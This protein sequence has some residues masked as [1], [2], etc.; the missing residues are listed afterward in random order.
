MSRATYPG[1]PLSHLFISLILVQTDTMLF[2]YISINSTVLVLE[3]SDKDLRYLFPLK[4]I[5]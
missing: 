2:H 5:F 1:V 4:Y 3:S